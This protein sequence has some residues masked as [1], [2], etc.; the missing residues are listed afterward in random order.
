[1]SDYQNVSC[2][3]DLSSADVFVSGESLSGASAAALHDATRIARDAGARLHLVTGLDLDALAAWM[4]GVE[5]TAGRPTVADHA[6][7]RLEALAVGPRNA[8]IVTTTEVAL[9]GPAQALMEDADREGRDLVVVGTRE[10]GAVARNVLGSTALRLLRRAPQDVWVAREGAAERPQ[11]VLASIDLGDMAPRIVA[12]AARVAAHRGAPLH[13]VHVVDFRAEDVLRTG[14]A[15]AQ[16]VLEYRRR[17]RLRA[18]EE[19]PAI[20]EQA[21]GKNPAL[22][23]TIHLPDGDVDATILRAAADTRATIV[24]LGSVVHS[25]VGAAIS[26]LGRTAEKVLPELGASLLVLKPRARP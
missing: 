20:V 16:F 1:M 21:L 22:K 9:A 7:G 6:K 10:R 19:V 18:E 12:A 11:V 2:G 25:A 14:A 13:V 3:L 17:K 15:D 26:G 5:R 4:V 24:V 8:G 23:P